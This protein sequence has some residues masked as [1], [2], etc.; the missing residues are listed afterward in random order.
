MAIPALP[1]WAAVARRFGGRRAW[2]IA[3]AGF[4]ASMTAVYFASDFQQGV[5]AMSLAC[6][7]L[8]GLLVAPDLL[9]SDL[10]DEDETV[11]GTRRE[12]MYFGINGFV[13]RFAFT[14]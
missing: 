9:I 7:G 2:Q 1:L 6:L 11:T 8:A 13:I 4:A 5:A 3:Q 10:I 14:T 12:G